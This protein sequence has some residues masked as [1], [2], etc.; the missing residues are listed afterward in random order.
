MATLW[1]CPKR[2]CPPA[3]TAP[4]EVDDSRV[5]D[6]APSSMV[7]VAELLVPLDTVYAWNKKGAGRRF[8]VIGKRVRY[9]APDVK[10]WMTHTA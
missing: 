1:S 10:E 7:D 5:Q 3:E 2:D 9:V 4:K 8:Y 6:H